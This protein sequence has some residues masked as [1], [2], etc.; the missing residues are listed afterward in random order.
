MKASN[1]IQL[2][3]LDFRMFISEKL[4]IVLSF[5]LRKVAFESKIGMLGMLVLSFEIALTAYDRLFPLK[6]KNPI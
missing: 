1:T 4:G 2:Y 3:I 5:L 6:P